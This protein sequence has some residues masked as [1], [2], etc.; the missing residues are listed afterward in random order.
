MISRN[1]SAPT[2]AAISIECTT[3]ANKTVTCLY[4]AEAALR[5]SGVPHSLQNFADAASGLP[6]DEHDTSVV[7]IFRIVA[8]VESF[9]AR[10]RQAAAVAT[11]Q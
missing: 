11:T 9:G 3:S 10:N 8:L 2:D 5:L 4:S 7:V 1:R 6:H